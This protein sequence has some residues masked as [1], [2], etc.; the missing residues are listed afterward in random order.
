MNPQIGNS[1]Q[2]SMN[3]LPCCS[4]KQCHIS[5]VLEGIL[6]EKYIE[7]CLIPHPSYCRTNMTPMQCTCHLWQFITSYNNTLNFIFLFVKYRDR[8]EN[9]RKQHGEHRSFSE[10]I[11]GG[12]SV[13]RGVIKYM[14][15]FEIKLLLTFVFQFFVTLMR[16]KIN[17]DWLYRCNYQ[18]FEAF[19]W[20]NSDP[21]KRGRPCWNSLY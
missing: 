17:F 10:M 16:G 6:D 1:S 7:E 3:N 20:D 15:L 11:H 5:S 13:Y 9:D 8:N 4:L 19:V 2:G 12:K 18:R 14:I 21:G